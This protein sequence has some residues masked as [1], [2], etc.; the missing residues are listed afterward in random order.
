LDST[1]NIKKVDQVSIIIRYVLLNYEIKKIEIKELF[2]GFFVLDKHNAVDYANLLRQTL[3]TFGLNINKCFGQG[4]DCVEVMS[5]QHSG[6]Q[7]L[8]RSNFPNA[9]YV[10]C[11]AHNLNLVISDVAKSSSKVQTFFI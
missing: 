11:C 5:G 6:V 1:Q 9:V 4:Y 2:L 10:H 7:T 3:L 8:I